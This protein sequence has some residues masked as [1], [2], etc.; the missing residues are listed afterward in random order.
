LKEVKEV[1]EVNDVKE[2]GKPLKLRPWRETPVL[3]FLD[4]PHVLPFR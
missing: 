3:H 2:G 1:R 4:I